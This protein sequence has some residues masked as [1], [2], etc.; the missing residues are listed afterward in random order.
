VTTYTAS[1]PCFK[2]C[3]LSTSEK[4]YQTEL[5]KNESN[6]LEW[7]NRITIKGVK[8]NAKIVLFLQMMIRNKIKDQGV[9]KITMA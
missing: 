3:L 8:G 5:K 9:A 7:H 1:P 6:P 4:Q 2:K